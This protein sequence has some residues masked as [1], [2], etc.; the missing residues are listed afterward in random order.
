[1]YN[2]GHSCEYYNSNLIIWP[3]CWTHLIDSLE[4]PRHYYSD[5]DSTNETNKNAM[6]E[7]QTAIWW[8]SVDNNNSKFKD[9]RRRCDVI[10][11]YQSEYAKNHAMENIL[12]KVGGASSD[13]ETREIH[14]MVL[15]M[16]EFIPNRQQELNLSNTIQEER[17]LDVLFNPFKG[18]HY[19]DEIRKRS[20]GKKIRFTPI[21]GGENG[22]ERI[23]PEEVTAILHRGKIYIDFGPHPGMDRIPREAA[24]AN[25]V[26]ITNKAGAA[27]YTEDVPIPEQ[28]KVGKFDVDAIHKILMRSLEDYDQRKKDFDDYRDWI[29]NQKERM[30]DCVKGLLESVGSKRM[31]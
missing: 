21:G 13:V 11:L 7:N 9:W 24:L 18:M 10:H 16:T 26:V 2:E 15:P 25:C 20:E 8:L 4:T 12:P 31:V 27:A 6:K 14:N 17:D 3:E 30:E 29:G 28:Y 5:N 19:T 22:D 23:S 1:M